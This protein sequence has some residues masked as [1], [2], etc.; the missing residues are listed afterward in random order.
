M[1]F[2]DNSPVVPPANDG[3]VPFMLASELTMAR[4]GAIDSALLAE[5]AFYGTDFTKPLLF[6]ED[7]STTPT[8]RRRRT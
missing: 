8:W 2:V 1:K 5:Q 4:S 3:P 7:G 6:L